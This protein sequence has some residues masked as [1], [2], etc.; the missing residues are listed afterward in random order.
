MD[1]TEYQARTVSR[2][3]IVEFVVRW[4]SNG[5]S[6]GN[7]AHSLTLAPRQTRRI[8]KVD[9]ERS[10]RAT[11]REE[12]VS[13]DEVEQAT[14][15][16]RDY[17]DAVQSGL[18]EWSRGG[19]KASVT[20]A[21]GGVGFGVPGFVI[22]G[23]AAHSSS[24]SS[25]WQQ[26]GR[27]VSASEQQTLRDSIRQ[28]GDSLRS[29]ES[30]VVTEAEQG[31]SVEGVSEVV[32]N[33]NYCHALSII[34]YDILRHLRV[35]TEVGGVRECLFVPLS[36]EEFDDARIAKHQ[37]VL[38]RYVPSGDQRNVLRH[39]EDLQNNFAN[40]EIPA[41]QRNEQKLTYL[42]GSIDLRLSITR[43][44][45]GEVAEKV[46]EGARREFSETERFR[47]MVEEF[48]KF[49]I[50]LPKP[51]TEIVHDLHKVTEGERDRYFQRNIAPHMARRFA[52]GLKIGRESGGSFTPLD[53]DFTLAGNYQ[54]GRTVRVEFTVD[55]DDNLTRKETEKLIIKVPDGLVLPPQS[56]ADVMHGRISFATDHYQRSNVYSDRGARDLIRTDTGQPD[57]EGADLTFGFTNYERADLQDELREAYDELKKELNENIY[58]YH[59]A[60]WWNMDRDALYTLLDGFAISDEDGRSIASL[61]EQQPIGILGNALVFRV[62]AG[63][64]I[65]PNF[66]NPQA[67]LNYYRAETPKSDPLRV[68]LPTSGLYAR[69]HMDDCNA[70]EEHRGTQDWVLDN[71]D[72]E[73]ANLPESLLQSRRSQPTELTPTQFPGTLI[74][75]QNAPNA[76]EPA[77][78]KDILEA[79]ASADSFRDMA[80]LVGTQQAAVSGL[81]TAAGLATAFGQNMTVRG[82]DH[83][84]KEVTQPWR[85]SH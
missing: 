18:S 1:T 42:N 33:I 81:Q 54:Y 35:D 32:R 16:N 23:G 79:T 56:A 13:S 2:G 51:P 25:S 12:T 82:L 24:S 76:P 57:P 65:D 52:D 15:R 44:R 78:L 39:L 68:S 36:I 6:L 20:A 84:P 67:L 69:A 62:S 11:R 83:R 60:V 59:K 10:E 66:K 63:T 37:E 47:K 80:G 3:H 53:A 19:S 17:S 43:P 45:E 77:G 26:G 58:R 70:C 55:V 8:V 38:L 41:G 85:S 29:L 50:F 34:Y 4:R 31:E 21:A 49:S 64:L 46:E 5:Y 71:P 22:G 28:Y 75:L 48:S 72:P 14:I 9:Y 61:V 40:S 30:T 74:N 7:V 73:L 27:N